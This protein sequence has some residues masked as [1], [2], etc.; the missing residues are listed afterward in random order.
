MI[1]KKEIKFYSLK[2]IDSIDF[3]KPYLSDED[4]FELKVV[5]TILPFKTNNYIIEELIDWTNIPNDPIFQLNFMLKEMISEHQFYTIA[6]LFKSGASKEE[7]SNSAKIFRQELNPH[8]AGQ[9]IANVPIMDSVT[10]PGIQHKYDKTALFFPSEGQTCHSYCTFCFRWAQFVG[11]HDLKFATDASK[12]FLNYLKL[13]KEI[14]DILITGGDPLI[15]SLQKLESYILP[16]LNKEFDHIKNIRI[17]TKSLSY[18]P[19]RFVTDKDANGILQLFEKVRNS[20]KQI[21][22]MAHINHYVEL[23]TEIVKEAVKRLLNVGVTIRTQSPII[24]HINDSADV[25]AEN[26]KKQVSLG[27]FPYYVFIARNTGAK[28]YFEVPLSRA[29]EIYSD[30]FKKVSG[31][32]RTARGPVMSANPGK[33]V[34]NGISTIKGEKVFALNFLQARNPD[35]VKHPFFAKYDETS[36]WLTQL[37]P[38]F[39]EKKFFY[40]DELAAILKQ[41]VYEKE[42]NRKII[43][44]NLESKKHNSSLFE[45]CF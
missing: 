39:G 4:I 11:Y 28:G 20:G 30:A 23:D 7:I 9:L 34:I 18:W 29:F 5:G 1:S 17:G 25:W 22:F 38:A 33:V 44:D 21:A 10:V 13:H 27:M 6:K 8:P 32:Q 14:S 24:N 40:E 3:I 12:I 31:L 37:T 15:M 2:D 43:K 41:K 42:K 36:T 45:L 16:F 26:W 19:Y 35:W